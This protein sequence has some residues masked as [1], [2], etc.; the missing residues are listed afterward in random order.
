MRRE[1]EFRYSQLADKLRAQILSGEIQ[2]GQFLMSENELCKHYGV[3]RVTVRKSLDRLAKEGLIVKKAGQGSMVPPDLTIQEGKRQILR[4]VS[5]SPSFFVDHCM[6]I[7]IE[8]FQARQPEVEVKV[9]SFPGVE[10]WDVIHHNREVGFQPDLMLLSD[11]QYHTIGQSGD[12]VDL[13]PVLDEEGAALY[14]RLTHAFRNKDTVRA[15]PVSFSSVYLV[16]NPHLFEKYKVPLPKE[17]WTREDFIRTAQK[18][19]IDTNGDGIVD[20]YGFSLANQL[21]RWTVMALQHGVDFRDLRDPGALNETLVF[22]HDLL[23]RYRVAYLHRES[24]FSPRT[25]PFLHEKSAMMLTSAME[26]AGLRGAGLS[27]RPEVAH[28]PFGSVN[29]TFLLANMIAIPSD[30]PQVNAAVDF[31]RTA[32][33]PEVQ[34]EV[35]RKT[36]FLSVLPPIN[37]KVWHRDYLEKLNIAGEQIE[38]NLFPHEVIPDEVQY[39]KLIADMQLYWAGLE[40]AGECAERIRTFFGG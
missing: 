30:S 36:G 35:A 24:D 9:I 34:E 33:D 29:K 14:P 10:F 28:L 1:N 39:G 7:I 21:N 2:P 18:L 31:L 20:M 37:E 32:L 12:F 22:M 25:H 13:R 40:T 5:V 3:S 15:A 16:Y 4:I 26:L 38:A 27:F 23:Y 8:R 6:P 19:T 11:M 17:K